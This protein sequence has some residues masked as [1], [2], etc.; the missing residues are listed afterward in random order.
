MLWFFLVVL[1]VYQYDSMEA[2]YGIISDTDTYFYVNCIYRIYWE[3]NCILWLFPVRTGMVEAGWDMKLWTLV[4][5][6]VLIQN[7]QQIT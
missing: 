3:C 2:Q 1:D 6:K 4:P 5:V 7:S